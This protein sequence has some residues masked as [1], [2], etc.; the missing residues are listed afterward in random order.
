MSIVYDSV[1]KM[2]S[3]SLNIWNVGLGLAVVGFSYSRPFLTEYMVLPQNRLKPTDEQ[4]E[5]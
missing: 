2:M 3:H 1:I 4:S 5:R